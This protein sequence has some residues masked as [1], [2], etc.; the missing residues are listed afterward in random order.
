MIKCLS[1]KRVYLTKE[2]AET[3]LLE[4]RARYTYGNRTGPV[5]VY[6]CEDC[7]QYHLT[8]SGAVNEKLAEAQLSGTLKRQQVAQEWLDKL[9][10]K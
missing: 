4:A 5:A 7:G 10:H 1:H 6:H 2:M 8:S 3:A 9:K